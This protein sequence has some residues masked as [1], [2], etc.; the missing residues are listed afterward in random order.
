MKKSL[1][2]TA[3]GAITATFFIPISYA[4]AKN[5]NGTFPHIDGNSQFPP[6]RFSTVRHTFRVHIPKNSSS[7]SQLDIEVPNTL[8]WSNNANDIV[9]TNENGKKVN[10]SISTTGK[11]ILIAFAEPV[12]SDTKLEIDIKNVKQPFRG[13]GP[14]YN[15]K[16]KL[17]GSSTEMFI[18]TARFRIN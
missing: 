14:I 10:V 12:A 3:I 15:I 13:N 6:T 4:S 8:T 17:A 5:N 18:G 9:V 7:V 11:S 2:Y 1:I 16:A